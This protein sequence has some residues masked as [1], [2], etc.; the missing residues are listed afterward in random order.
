MPAETLAV[1]CE[2]QLHLEIRFADG[3]VALSTFGA[4]PL[5]CRLGDGTLTPALESHLQGL[6]PGIET[7][8]S[9]AGSDLFGP[10]DACNRHWMERR[11]FPPEV[12]PTPGHVIYFTTPSGH[13]TTGTVLALDGERV[14]VDFNHPFCGRQLRLRIKLLKIGIDTPRG[15]G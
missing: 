2:I 7:L 8:L 6:Q 11:D 4:E 13:E 3:A 14:Q 10:Y 12:A 1:G 5:V 9:A 15:P